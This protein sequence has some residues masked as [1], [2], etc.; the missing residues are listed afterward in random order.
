MKALA[1]LRALTFSELISIAILVM[2]PLLLL[3]AW[4]T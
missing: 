2:T 1:I 4:L 3:Y